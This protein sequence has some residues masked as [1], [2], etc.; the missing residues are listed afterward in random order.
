MSS[1]CFSLFLAL[2]AHWNCMARS[3]S[4]DV[5]AFYNFKT[6]Q[7]STVCKHNDQK[8]DKTGKRLSEKS[9]YANPFDLNQLSVLGQDWE[10]TLN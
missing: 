10:S 8:A 5:S 9:I 4:I 7:N 3:A 1:F 2:A 6:S